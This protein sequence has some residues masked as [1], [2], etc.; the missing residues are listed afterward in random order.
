M[1]RWFKRLARPGITE[2]VCHYCGGRGCARCSWSGTAF[3]IEWPQLVLRSGAFIALFAAG[4][5]F[6]AIITPS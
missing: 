1:L 6:V 5:L 3:F 2:E 4:F